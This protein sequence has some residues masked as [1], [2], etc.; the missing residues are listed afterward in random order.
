MKKKTRFLSIVVCFGLLMALNT[1]ALAVSEER[2]APEDVFSEAFLSE[3]RVADGAYAYSIASRIS[4]AYLNGPAAFL[5]NMEQLNESDYNLFLETLV[6]TMYYESD[7]DTFKTSLNERTDEDNIALDVLAAAEAYEEQELAW[8]RAY[9]E[10]ISQPEP[11]GLFSPEIVKT[12]IEAHSN[13][14]I[15]DQ[16]FCGYLREM[17]ELDPALFVQTIG[18]FSNE[19]ISKIAQQISYAQYLDLGDVEGTKSL[20]YGRPTSLESLDSSEITLGNNFVATIDSFE[21]ASIEEAA[22]VSSSAAVSP[23]DSADAIAATTTIG[24]MNYS[25][26]VSPPT[27]LEIN[28]AAVLTT[29]ISGLSANTQY[30]VELWAR[31]NG[32]TTNNLKTTT[33]YTSNSSGVI[34]ASLNVTFSSPGEIWTTV[35]VYKGST[36]VVSRTGSATDKIYAR[37]RIDLP[38]GSDHYGTLSFYYAS[39]SKAYSC[40]ALGKSARNRPYTQVEGHTPPGDYYGW[41]A[42]LSGNREDYPEESYGPNKVIKMVG[43][44]DPGYSNLYVDSDT[45][46]SKLRN[47][48]WIHGGRSQS[49]YTSTY[50][51]VRIHDDD[52]LTITNYMDSWVNAGYHTRGRVSITR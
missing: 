42:D 12:A 2:Y 41:T 36:L 33:T 20:A 49:S 1:S 23:Q 7:W 10:Y 47:G 21:D 19:D 34:N 25:N 13:S 27:Q 48:I 38:L 15:Y 28:K 40:L 29:K 24:S 51:C 3:A 37:W 11:E 26:V 50:G 46:T 30:K 39:G 31:H 44:D 45:D 4:K 8:E 22:M 14:Y 5:E 35:K 52:I 18:D 17:Y 9:E 16:E 6:S 32:S 43:N